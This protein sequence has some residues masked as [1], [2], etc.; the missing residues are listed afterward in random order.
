VN[1]DLPDINDLRVFV[2]VAQRSSFAAA[3]VDLGMSPAYMTKRIKVLES[4]LGATLLNRTTR[5]VVVTEDG[6]RTYQWAQKILDD[7]DHLFDDISVKRTDPKGSLRV[8][9]SFGFGRNIVSPAIAALAERYPA[10]SI[11]F[12]VFDRLIDVGAE[13]FDLDVRIGDEIAPYH[14]ARKLASNYRVLCASPAY[15]GKYGSPKT[16][17]DLRNHSCLIIKE[18][19]HPFGVWRVRGPSGEESVKVRGQLSTNHG[20]I[21]V[22]WSVAGRGIILRS[23]WDVKPLLD[24]GQLVRILPQYIQEA[25]VWAVYP[26]R[27]ESSAKIKACI[28]WLERHLLGKGSVERKA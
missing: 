18:R 28:D 13:G 21:A 20:E 12:E 22:S 11:R 26:E 8:C 3:A 9:S 10:L 27:L 15:I 4:T 2:H 19:D 7:V 23:M 5:R 1:G 14:I 16:L 17:S 24:S 6:E 25:N